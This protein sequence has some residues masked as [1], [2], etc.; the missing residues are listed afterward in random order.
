MELEKFIE[1]D[2]KIR[3]LL[4]DT[5]SSLKEENLVLKERLSECEKELKE[6]K[7]VVG[8]YDK[9]KLLVREKVDG[10]LQRVEGLIR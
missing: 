5:G 10:L 8:R 9:E 1:L 4:V 3:E 2:E 6:L 7:R